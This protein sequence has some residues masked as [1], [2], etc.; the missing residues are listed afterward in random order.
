MLLVV[1]GEG[2]E[3]VTC[4]CIRRVTFTPFVVSVDG[5]L[6]QANVLIKR[7]AEKIAVEV[8]KVLE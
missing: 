6:G 1:K 8:G 7:L 5:V 2:L 4:T 3:L